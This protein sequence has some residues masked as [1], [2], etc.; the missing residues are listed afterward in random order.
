MGS[1]A[2]NHQNSNSPGRTQSP[3][4]LF[5]CFDVTERLSGYNILKFLTC[6]VRHNCLNGLCDSDCDDL[7]NCSYC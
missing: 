3:G 2:K 7:H 1:F 4:L 6:V 5:V